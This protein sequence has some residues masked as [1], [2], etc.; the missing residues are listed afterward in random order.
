MSNN[1]TEPAMV[2]KLERKSSSG[3]ET[4]ADKKITGQ[5][6]GKKGAQGSATDNS[7]PD[8]SKSDRTRTPN[9]SDKSSKIGTK[10]AEK[11]P[12]AEVDPSKVPLKSSNTDSDK[13]ASKKSTKK[14]SDQ[15]VTKLTDKSTKGLEIN[16]DKIKGTPKSSI[17]TTGTGPEPQ[18]DSTDVTTSTKVVDQNTE[19]TF[20]IPTPVTQN[21]TQEI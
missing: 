8:K 20:K 19:P 17:S 7:E 15:V 2:N 16:S 18:V 10:K 3:T 13:S 14:G 11:V 12:L 21:E 1:E 5:D 6:Q 9:S 4:K